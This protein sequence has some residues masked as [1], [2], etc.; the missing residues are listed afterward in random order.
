MSH[1]T[2]TSEACKEVLE[3]DWNDDSTQIPTILGYRL[4]N[5]PYSLANMQ[6][7]SINLYGQSNGIAINRKYMRFKPSDET[8]LQMLIDTD[9]ELTD[10]PLDYYLVQEG[11]YYDQ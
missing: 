9:I 7:A 4:Q 1:I 10:Y 8:Q 5:N 2:S 6:Q 3:P 11:D